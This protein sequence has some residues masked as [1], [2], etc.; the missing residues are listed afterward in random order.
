MK[1][2]DGPMG[3]TGLSGTVGR[4]GDQGDKLVYGVKNLMSAMRLIKQSY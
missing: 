2:P 1:G 3:L 4:M